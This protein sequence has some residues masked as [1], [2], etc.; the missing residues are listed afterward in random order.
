MSSRLHN[1]VLFNKFQSS[2]FISLVFFACSFNALG[3]DEVTTE[4]NK[5]QESFRSLFTQAGFHIEYK[6]YNLAL[7]LFLKMDSLKP[8]NANVQY[9]IGQCYLESANDKEKAISYLEKAITNTTTNY[10]DLAYTEEKA[11]IYAYLDLGKAYHYNYQMDTAI[12]TLKKLK[13]LL[14]AK[15]YMQSDAMRLIEM[16]TFAKQQIANPIDVEIVN[17]G[18]DIN[19]EY[20]DF[21][22]VINADES[23]MIFTSR[24]KGTTG[25]GTTIDGKYYEDIYVSYKEAG[26]WTEPQK[27]GPSI[28]TSEHDA[29][30]G[31][32]ADGQRLFVYKDDEGD[33]NIYQSF[34]VGEDW[35]VP[36]KLNENIN[37]EKWETHAS[38][39][40]KGD[41]LYFVSDRNGGMG[42]R[43][44]YRCKT[45]PNGEWA[46]PE[47]IGPSINT[48]YDEDA[49]FIHPNGKMLFFSSK[50]HETMG[51]FDILFSEMDENGNWGAAQN[52]GYPINTTLDDIY[53]VPSTDGQRGYYSSAAN[54]GYGDVDLYMAAYKGMEEIA[55]TVLKGVMAVFDNE[56]IPV[57][58]EI[59]V[60][61]NSNPDSPALIYTPNSSTGKYII[62]LNAGRD[63]NV[64]YMI[65][66]SIV[67]SENIFI[68]EESSYQEIERTID[69]KKID[70]DGTI[71]STS[72]EDEEV[73]ETPIP[74]NTD[75]SALQF[76]YN[77]DT[78]YIG[79]KQ[80][81]TKS[82]SGKLE[83]ISNG[84]PSKIYKIMLVNKEGEMV[85]STLTDENGEF[86]FKEIPFDNQ[87]LIMTEKY[88]PEAKMVIHKNGNNIVTLKSKDDKQ[89]VKVLEEEETVEEPVEDEYIK[90]TIKDYREYFIYNAISIN[91]D[92]VY[93]TQFIEELTTLLKKNDQLKLT[94][95]ASASKVPTY[96]YSNN[97]NL[98][99]T[100]GK[101]AKNSIISA[102][103]KKG[104]DTKRITFTLNV[105]VNGPKYKNDAKSNKVVYEKY[106]YVFVK[107]NI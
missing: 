84:E 45:L 16:C 62:I 72:P 48:P 66:D 41:L 90:E 74:I 76:F 79:D 6:N 1:T 88:L 83:N 105:G 71:A 68:P 49:P 21:G 75:L 96:K 11:P 98:A 85:Y 94:I 67:H 42:G 31:L 2:L 44:I 38:I 78:S 92:N 17:L 37:S 9:R 54:T 64:A 80:K 61:D 57:T 63:Y 27:I 14:H 8:D 100:R 73:K 50:G 22:P 65:N 19:T 89:F 101:S 53:Y 69:L 25:R 43:D 106:Q 28:N 56:G 103:S 33:G 77:T 5:E 104:I 36:E 10:N 102:L 93:F 32:S 20:A 15:H 81:L 26:N 18:V 60:T 13:S 51:G 39:S 55:L 52:I 24:R 99:S 107:V 12:S 95:D 86:I 40:A 97:S 91:T 59:L 29:A 87:Y 46:L 47:N 82:I 4:A 34:L 58:A 7:P 3:Q 70:A 23:M 30:I 35:T